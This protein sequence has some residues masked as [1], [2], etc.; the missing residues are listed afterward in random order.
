MGSPTYA[1]KAALLHLQTMKEKLCK[2]LEP[3]PDSGGLDENGFIDAMVY[4]LDGPEERAVTAL[5]QNTCDWTDAK[6]EPPEFSEAWIYGGFEFG[7]WGQE[8][9]HTGP[10]R[11]T[12][13]NGKW[14]RE[15]PRKTDPVAWFTPTHY[16]L[17][18]KIAEPTEPPQ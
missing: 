5:L 2:F 17:I 3:D 18:P 12:F 11:V 10:T 13:E 15:H 8:C 4:L 16:Q 14:A 9:D 6:K 1:E 7:G